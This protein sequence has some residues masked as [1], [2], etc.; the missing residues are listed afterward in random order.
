MIPFII[1]NYK[2][3]KRVAD[4]GGGWALGLQPSA[5]SPFNDRLHKVPYGPLDP[6]TL[7]NANIR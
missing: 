7:W 6:T 2:I 4:R 3:I 5:F 1:I